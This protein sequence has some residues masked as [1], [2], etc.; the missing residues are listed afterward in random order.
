LKG[1][2]PPLTEAVALPL[3]PVQVEFVLVADS[4]TGTTVLMVKEA[5]SVQ[6][7]ASVMVTV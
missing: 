2:V 6:L 4:N 7:L 3:F 5:V 1:A